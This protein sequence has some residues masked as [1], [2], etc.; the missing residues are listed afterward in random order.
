LRRRGAWKL[1]VYLTTA[2]LS[3]GLLMALHV[4][5]TN[6]RGERGDFAHKP[7]AGI[8]QHPERVGIAGLR[9]ISFLVGAGS[10]IAGWYVPSRNRA[11][12]LL[13]H[14]AQADR[15]SLIAE[16]RILAGADFGVLALDL[17]GQGASDGQSRWGV[18]EREAIIAAGE[19]LSRRED[20]D[21]NRIGAFGLSM[22]AYVLTQAAV[23][24]KRLRAL[25]LAACPTDVVEQN[26]VTSGKWGLLSR[27]PS[28]L[29]L[30]ASGM[31]LDRLPKNIIGMIA[32]RPV[33]IL[34]G[35]L[36]QTV[37]DYMARELFARAGNPKELWII[38]GAHHGDYAAIAPHEYSARLV[39]FYRRTLLN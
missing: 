12:V 18:P 2:I 1:A 33:L 36:D 31:P 39:N 25:T 28:Y 4:V 8:S 13:I 11:A 37:P 5:V 14:G 16:T 15:S 22:G 30:W 29:A 3:L 17:P 23:A 34:A 19:W 32:P 26:W 27:V 6:Y 35:D 24:D 38:S 9:E 10:R 20:V 21:Q 7:A